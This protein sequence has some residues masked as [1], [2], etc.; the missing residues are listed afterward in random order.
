ML[1]QQTRYSFENWKFIEKLQIY[2]I[3]EEAYK[4]YQ[5]LIIVTIKQKL[6]LHEFFGTLEIIDGFWRLRAYNVVFCLKDITSTSMKNKWFVVWEKAYL[7]AIIWIQMNLVEVCSQLEHRQ[8]V[9]LSV[10]LNVQN[11]RYTTY[12]WCLLN[13]IR[14]TNEFDWILNE[15]DYIQLILEIKDK[16]FHYWDFWRKERLT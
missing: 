1:R 9:I 2:A 16:R 6:S 14:K 3:S 5:S 10:R 8:S 15:L 4:I 11:S 7:L 13:L 12:F